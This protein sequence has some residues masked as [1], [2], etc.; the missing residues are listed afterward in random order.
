MA[1]RIDN[2][3]IKDKF[4]GVSFSFYTEDE[5]KKLS[6]QQIMDPVAFNH[7]NNPNPGG[8]HDKKLGVSPFDHKSQCPTCGMSVN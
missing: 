8:L 1:H 2:H 7:L 4:A 6:V 5:I 3:P